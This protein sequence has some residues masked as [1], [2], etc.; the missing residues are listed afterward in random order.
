MMMNADGSIV[1]SLLFVKKICTICSIHGRNQAGK[2]RIYRGMGFFS[3]MVWKRGV[4]HPQF[5]QRRKARQAMRYSGFSTVS[6]V[7]IIIIYN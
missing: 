1:F 5:I 2:K 3:T 7:I 6:T 4:I